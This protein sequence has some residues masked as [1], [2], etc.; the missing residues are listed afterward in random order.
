MCCFDSISSVSPFV[1]YM[2]LEDVE[3]NYEDET[4]WDEH[5]TAAIFVFWLGLIIGLLVGLFIGMML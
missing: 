2:G 5:T 1:L 4:S 3:M